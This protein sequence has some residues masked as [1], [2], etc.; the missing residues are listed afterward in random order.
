MSSSKVRE[1]LSETKQPC[2]N[3]LKES[4]MY[5][6]GAEKEKTSSKP[7]KHQEHQELFTIEV[8]EESSTIRRVHCG[9]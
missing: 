2:Y 7:K 9:I 3:A 1:L 5:S 4:D 8:L 6:P